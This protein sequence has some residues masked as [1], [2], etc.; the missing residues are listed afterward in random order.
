MRHGWLIVTAIVL[1]GCLQ[2]PPGPPGPPGAQGPPGPGAEGGLAGEATT[3][4]TSGTS[5]GSVGNA[6]PAFRTFSGSL[7]NADNSGTSLEIFTGTVF[8]ANGEKDLRQATLRV[9]VTGPATYVSNH[10]VTMPESTALDEPASFGADGWKVWSAT[11]NDGVLNFKFRFTFPI[12]TTPGTYAIRPTV[13]PAGGSAVDGTADSTVVA[14]FSEI[15]LSATPVLPSGAASASNSWGLWTATPGAANVESTN[16]VK[17]VNTGQKATASV[18]LDFTEA[19]FTGPDANFTIPINGNVQF[20]WAELPPDTTAPSAGTYGWLAP[21]A[22]GSVTVTFTGLNKVI[23]V[24]Y[25]IAALPE[26]L[27]AQSYGASYT[28]TEV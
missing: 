24:K 20:A 14:V 11:A 9:A 4:G 21:S 26:V 16:F 10:T 22:D 8:D 27:A 25:R 7:A 1:G 2:G 15:S 18:V 28:A 13:V 3:G 12:G 6:A 5:G 23:F 17:L 19:G